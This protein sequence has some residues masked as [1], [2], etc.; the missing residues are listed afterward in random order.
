MTEAAH[1][2]VTRPDADHTRSARALIELGR[3]LG[4]EANLERG[5]E[6][7]YEAARAGVPLS[8]EARDFA[9]ALGLA[10]VALEQTEQ[11]EQTVLVK[12]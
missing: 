4:L 7:L 5:Q 8:A 2:V 12:G 6:I 9:L 11:T 1:L 10:P 3:D